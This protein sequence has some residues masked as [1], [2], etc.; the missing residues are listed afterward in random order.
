MS[1][2][3]TCG[4]RFY[5]DSLNYCTDECW[6]NSIEYKEACKLCTDFLESLTDKQKDAFRDIINLE[7][8][9]IGVVGRKFCK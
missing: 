3:K 9:Y 4:R 2:C 8:D 5:A 1:I 7:E 6:E